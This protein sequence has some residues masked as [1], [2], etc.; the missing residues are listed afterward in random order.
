MDF[1]NIKI[2]SLRREVSES[3][4]LTFGIPKELSEEFAFTPG[5]Y[6]TIA[7]NINGNIVRRAYSISSGVNSK[8]LSILV[9]K[10]EG[11]LVSTYLNDELAISE[12]ILIHSPNG[13]FTLEVSKLK[14]DEH[15]IFIGAGSGIT[16]L[17]SMIQ[18]VLH[19]DKQATCH[20]I[21]GSRDYDSI[22]YRDILD[23]L[24]LVYKGRLKVDHFLSQPTIELS[25]LSEEK[26]GYHQGRVDVAFL[27]DKL[28]LISEERLY[29]VYLCGPS[30]LID[31]SVSKLTSLKIPSSKVHRE[32]FSVPLADEGDLKIDFKELPARKVMVLLNNEEIELSMDDD[33]DILRKLIELDYDPPYSCLQG[34]CSTCK[35]KLVSGEV[36]MR[37]DIGLEA[38]EK[39]A[40][41]ILT[42]QSSPISP[43]VVCRY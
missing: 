26:Q 42:C 5:Q 8:S 30:A 22:I 38:D 37:V 1:H 41:Y 9:K 3:V 27:E 40:G 34:T 31:K 12:K 2:K 33:M 18:S 39:E 43:T 32:Y 11:G 4:E 15:I 25:N 23:R 36:Q 35:A 29:G 19:S 6:L 28:N 20:L 24:Q 21:Y 13:N 10:L 14:D 17:M 7:L 16:P